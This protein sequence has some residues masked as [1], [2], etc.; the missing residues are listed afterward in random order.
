MLVEGRLDVLEEIDGEGVSFMEVGEVAVEAV[1]GVLVGEQ[2]G[3]LELPTEECTGSPGQPS[4]EGKH[5]VLRPFFCIREGGQKW[6]MGISGRERAYS[7]SQIK[8]TLW[9]FSPVLGSAIYVCRPPRVS[10]R[11]EGVP[12]WIA[13]LRQ[14]ELIPTFSDMIERGP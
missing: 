12:S 1:L 5:W 3:V 8:T 7:L 10:T 9:V 6:W 14:Q 11:P 2:A 13:P 4:R